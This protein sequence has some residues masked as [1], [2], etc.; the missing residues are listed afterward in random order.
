MG[1]VKLSR[2]ELYDL[3]WS[4][5]LTALAKQFEITLARIKSACK[6]KKIPIPEL[7]FWER[8]K[9]GKQTIIPEL[10]IDNSYWVNTPIWF[11]PT[12]ELC[13]NRIKQIRDEIEKSCKKF[14]IVPDNLTNADR[15]VIEAKYNLQT[16][17]PYWYGREEGYVSSDSEQI[18]IFVTKKN[19]KRALRLANALIKLVKARDHQIEFEN[20]SPKINIDGEKYDFSVREKQDRILNPGKG[21]E[22]IYKP[23]GLLVI[24]IGQYSRKREF[25]DNKQPLEKQLST[26]LA[27]LEYVTD[28]WKKTMAWH[29][30]Q[31]K[32]REEEEKVMLE[33]RKREQ[34]ERDKFR[35]LVRDAN[36]W[37][38]A[39]I[40][41]DYI[42]A[43]DIIANKNNV[44]T[45]NLK[46][47]I[48]WA[49][50]KVE[51]FD[52]L[53]YKL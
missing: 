21:N 8:K 11:T 7:G 49:R 3:V 20:Q 10:P 6:E 52:P 23:S 38:Q 35:K 39:V 33:A 50:K 43:V 30:A 22:F 4:T 28:D 24:S 14:C 25:L 31:R 44:E 27:Y 29:D 17:K 13:R 46:G 15:L 12:A 5:P 45:E 48:N 32:V 47:W 19:I 18:P 40:L 42:N 53:F 26:I 1:K 34:E 9:F 2:K 41:R 37:H 36:R 51:A 16:K